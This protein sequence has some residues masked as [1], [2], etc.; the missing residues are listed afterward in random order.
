L[1]FNEIASKKGVARVV[2]LMNAYTN[3]KKGIADMGVAFRAE[4][5]RHVLVLRYL[6]SKLP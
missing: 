6:A 2:S 4:I 5:E 3:T 1:F